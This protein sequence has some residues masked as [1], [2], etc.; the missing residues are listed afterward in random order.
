MRQT[1][2]IQLLVCCIVSLTGS[3]QRVCTVYSESKGHTDDDV[4]LDLA[5]SFVDLQQGNTCLTVTSEMS[6]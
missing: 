4:I 2:L 1:A 5:F 6:A 3:P